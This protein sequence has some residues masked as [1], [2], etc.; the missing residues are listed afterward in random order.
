MLLGIQ[1][2]S[3]TSS[4]DILLP[5]TP[6]RWTADDFWA[7]KGDTVIPSGLHGSQQPLGTNRRGL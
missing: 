7:G 5:S 1:S 2:C 6:D 4:L 3:G